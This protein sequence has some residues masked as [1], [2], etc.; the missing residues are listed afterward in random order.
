[1]KKIVLSTLVAVTLGTVSATAGSIKF[2]TDANGQVFVKPGEGR[3]ELNVNPQEVMNAMQTASQVVSS[4]EKKEMKE[5]IKAEL[6]KDILAEVKKSTP[7]FSKTSKLKFSGTHYLGYVQKNTQSENTGNFE[8]RRNYVQVK[9]YLFDDPKS[10]LRVTLDSTYSNSTADGEGHADVYVKYAYLYMNEILPY[11]GMEFGMVHRPWIDYEE[12]QGW[13]MRSL[14][15]VFVEASESSHLTNSADLGVNFKTKTPYF[16]FEVGVFNGEGYHGSNDGDGDEEHIGDGVS[17]EW[18]ATAAVLGNGEKKRKP[19]KDDYFDLS[20]FGQYNMDNSKN[21]T[22]DNAI[23]DAEDY[24]WYGFHTVYNT[25]SF[26]ISAQYVT[27]ENDRVNDS[28]WNGEG[29]SVNGTYRFGEK[30]QFSVIGRFDNWT[31]EKSSAVEYETN[32]AIYGVA[33]QQNK[34]FKWLLS[35]QSYD[36]K[37]GANYKGSAATNWTSAMLTAEVHW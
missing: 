17:V 32:N 11:T 33:W 18:R 31:A 10:Y 12:H 27:A 3:T 14:S 30:K 5:E 8:M 22:G 34:N 19:L 29:Y 21:A 16:T 24:V 25:P 9:A 7:V 35:G 15:K 26:L 13:W 4:S 37:D 1:M 2:Y 6:K 28:N 23:V 20:F 36:A